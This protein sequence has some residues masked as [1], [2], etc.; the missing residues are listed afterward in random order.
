[1]EMTIYL[2]KKKKNRIYKSEDIV[3]VI[4]ENEGLTEL[5]FTHGSS[6]EPLLNNADSSIPCPWKISVSDTKNYWACAI[7]DS[8]DIGIDI[9]EE[10]RTVKESVVKKLHV[11]EQQYLSGLET[12]SG[13]WTREFFAIWTRKEAYSKFCAAGLAIGFKRFSVID[14]VLEY[15]K[16]ISCQGRP[17]ASVTEL[18][19]PFGLYG[20]LCTE[21]DAPG[22]TDVRILKYDG[23]PPL[24]PLTAGAE[25]LSVKSVSTAELSAKLQK[26]GY[27]KEESD[28][29]ASELASRGYIDDSAYASRQA[30]LAARSGK[31]QNLIK[32]ELAG[33]GL[34]QS[35]IEQALENLSEESDESEFDRAFALAQKTLPLPEDDGE[36]PD[37]KQ[38]AKVARR[39]SSKGYAPGIIYSILEKYR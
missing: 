37:D 15:G 13:E 7:S 10:N 34:S 29:A 17:E 12:G 19:L 36:K 14:R 20:A 35:D 9:E 39:L 3:P 38:L 2:I 27:T 18:A 5:S 6:G 32:R 25:M 31:S 24:P 11:L 1:M 8:G 28:A 16:T 23:Q 30:V 22:E 26:K 21:H 33:K 4:L